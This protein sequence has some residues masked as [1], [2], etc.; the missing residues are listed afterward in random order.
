LQALTAHRKI[1]RN[2]KTTQCTAERKSEREDLVV[3]ISKQFVPCFFFL[4]L[5]RLLLFANNS[6]NNSSKEEK[7]EE[8]LKNI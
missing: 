2:K 1:G 8:I 7:R 5:D 3:E 4:Q 6:N